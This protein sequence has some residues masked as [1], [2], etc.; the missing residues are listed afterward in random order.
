MYK[1]HK[2][3]DTIFSEDDKSHVTMMTMDTRYGIL[4]TLVED[5]ARVSSLH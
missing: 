4:V 1:M 3:L 2:D 5:A